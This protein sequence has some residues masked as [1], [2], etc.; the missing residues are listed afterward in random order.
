MVL[1]SNTLT[2]VEIPTK[3]LT[4][5]CNHL[6]ISPRSLSPNTY[7][8]GYFAEEVR[9]EI[10]ERYGEKKLYDGGLSVRT[11]LDPTM[12]GITLPSS[13]DMAVTREIYRALKLVNIQLLEHLIFADNEY[14]SFVETNYM[15]SVRQ[16][17][18]G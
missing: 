5:C 12:R 16:S 14:L 4:R 1:G 10:A 2:V 18:Q 7:A 11:T 17:V 8:A 15:D 9:R 13:S 3:V 6:E